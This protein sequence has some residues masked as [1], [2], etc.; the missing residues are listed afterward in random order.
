MSTFVIDPTTANARLA[1]DAV[2]VSALSR[3][4]RHWV[5]AFAKS[6]GKHTVLSHVD[7][8]TDASKAEEKGYLAPDQWLET[9]YNYA[10]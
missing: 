3:N 6:Q 1:V 9:Y 2:K 7:I 5:K 10:V 4:Y 8:I